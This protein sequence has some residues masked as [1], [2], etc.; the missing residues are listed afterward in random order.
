MSRPSIAFGTWLSWIGLL[1]ILGEVVIAIV[2][3]QVFGYWL[4]RYKRNWLKLSLVWLLYLG[5]MA[6]LG[7]AF[8][9]ASSLLHFAL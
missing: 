6:L 2:A 5:V 9:W 3:Y 4:A 8:L 1:I 7:F